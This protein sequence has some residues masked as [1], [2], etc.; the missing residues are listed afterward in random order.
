MSWP[1][2]NYAENAAL[3]TGYQVTLT[4]FRQL[5]QSPSSRSAVAP[6]LK[7]WF[8]DD[9]VDEALMRSPEG[10]S[11]DLETLHHR[12]QNDPQMQYELYQAAM[13]LWH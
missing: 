4:A 11:I 1:P 5:I 10:Q 9:I 7:I 2:P 12:I 6:L 13:A 3:G 8:G